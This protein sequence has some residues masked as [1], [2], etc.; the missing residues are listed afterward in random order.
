MA[1]WAYQVAA[2]KKHHDS[3]IVNAH[4]AEV[5][6]LFR[7][8]VLGFHI[9]CVSC[10]LQQH[11]ASYLHD[12]GSDLKMYPSE[13]NK[14]AVSCQIA[15]VSLQRSARTHLPERCFDTLLGRLE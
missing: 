7:T 9:V 10:N 2:M 11:V 8:A 12:L 1:Q 4:G 6:I 15:L 5:L 3:L 13:G 14:P